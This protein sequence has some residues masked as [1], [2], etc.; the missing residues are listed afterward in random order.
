M[1]DNGGALPMLAQQLGP[2][3]AQFFSII[4]KAPA[5]LDDKGCG[6]FESERQMSEFVRE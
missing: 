5:R 2:S 3:N 1:L 6:L 4:V